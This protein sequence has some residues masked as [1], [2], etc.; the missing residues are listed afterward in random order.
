MDQRE[1][2]L[3]EDFIL[4][5]DPN[6]SR[7]YEVLISEDDDRMPPPDEGDPLPPDEVIVI[8]SWI[9][10]G[11]EWSD[12]TA[13]VQSPAVVVGSSTAPIKPP[14]SST[15]EFWL[16]VWRAFGDAHPA[17]VHFPIALIVVGG[18]FALFGLRGSY[19]CSD[20][21]FY[22]LWM[23]SITAIV[24]SALG[25][26]YAWNEGHNED[27]FLFDRQAEL[28]WHRWTG[29]L[30]AILSFL[31]ACWATIARRRNPDD[32]TLWKLCLIVLAG[33]TLYVGHA[34]GDLTHR[35]GYRR[36]YELFGLQAPA[37]PAPATDA[38][39]SPGASA[40]NDAAQNKAD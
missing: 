39:A 31:V 21:A 40:L 34:G 24:A 2:L 12:I 10:Q 33:F 3:T 29:V 27:P 37:N 5:G 26:S 30:L 13:L 17:A 11:A 36:I 18:V 7:L 8:K 20:F 9:E 1:I 15:E 4:P 25:W 32:G 23:G 22:C 6:N 14:L 28:F 35:R 19:R 16:K 38:P